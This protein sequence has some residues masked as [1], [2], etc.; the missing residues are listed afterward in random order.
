MYT[1]GLAE[2]RDISWGDILFFSYSQL[3][4]LAK[5]Y[6]SK[7]NNFKLSHRLSKLKEENTALGNDTTV[8]LSAKNPL[9]KKLRDEID[10]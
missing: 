6:K 5:I 4:G 2:T 1:K 10:H 3:F 8:F 9:S 7:P